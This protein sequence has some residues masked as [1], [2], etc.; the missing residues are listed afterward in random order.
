MSLSKIPPEISALFLF[1]GLVLILLG[2]FLLVGGML[3][4]EKVEGGGL[5]LIGPLPI[6]FHGELSPILLILLLILPILLFLV[7][8]VYFF[9]KIADQGR[10]L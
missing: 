3:P 10:E 7:F 2:V 8:A 5:I 1:V 9:H 4:Q 6:I